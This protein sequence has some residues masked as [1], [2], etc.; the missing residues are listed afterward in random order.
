ME[1]GDLVAYEYVSDGGEWSW[2]LGSVLS[3]RHCLVEILRWHNGADGALR[4]KEYD[5]F[6]RATVEMEESR[7]EELRLTDE[8]T[9]LRKTMI[10]RRA[11]AEEN[12]LVAK[13]RL[14]SAKKAVSSIDNTCLREMRTYRTPP[15][16]VKETL[17][18]VLHLLRQS[19]QP[20]TWENVQRL[21]RK[22]DFISNVLNFDPENEDTALN[23]SVVVNYLDNPAMTVDQVYQASRAAGPLLEWLFAKI[24]ATAAHVELKNYD[25]ELKQSARQMKDLSERL[26]L[27]QQRAATAKMTADD[28][29]ARAAARG[30]VLKKES[31]DQSQGLSEWIKSTSTADRDI[32]TTILS[33]SILC[34]FGHEN[35]SRKVLSPDELDAIKDSQLTARR[36]A[37]SRVTVALEALASR[38]RDVQELHESIFELEGHNAALAKDL[39]AL[40]GVERHLDDS[41]KRIATL[42]AANADLVLSNSALQTELSTLKVAHND[43]ERS[44]GEYRNHTRAVELH[45]AE[46]KHALVTQEQTQRDQIEKLTKELEQAHND[47]AKHDAHLEMLYLESQQEST[48]REAE[49]QK[50]VARAAE[51]AAMSKQDCLEATAKYDA[52][53]TLHETTRAQLERAT[54]ATM[55]RRDEV[56]GLEE[57]LVKIQQRYDESEQTLIQRQQD[58][59]A[60]QASTAKERT[61]WAE[62]KDNFKHQIDTQN[63][64]LAELLDNKSEQQASEVTVLMQT[65]QKFESTTRELEAANVT[66]TQRSRELELEV[67]AGK[68]AHA[69]NVIAISEEKKLLA[70]SVQALERKL[71][72][73]ES[74]HSEAIQALSASLHDA[75]RH[76]VEAQSYARDLAQAKAEINSYCA[77]VEEMQKQIEA[78]TKSREARDTEIRNLRDRLEQSLRE[79]REH[80]T[81]AAT[82]LKSQGAELATHKQTINALTAQHTIEMERRGAELAA[83]RE[84]LKNQQ[85]V[86]ES[87]LKSITTLA[88]NHESALKTAEADKAAL[89]ARLCE[90]A[91][92]IK[93]QQELISKQASDLAEQE[94]RIESSKMQF[95]AIAK[96]NTELA[97]SQER[98]IAELTYRLDQ[99]TTLLQKEQGVSD[100][101][102]REL[103]NSSKAQGNEVGKLTAE[104]NQSAAQARQL[105]QEL[106]EMKATAQILATTIER[107]TVEKSVMAREIE[108]L[109]ERNKHEIAVLH[110]QMEDLTTNVSSF[111][112]SSEARD[113]SK[114]RENLVDCEEMHEMQKRHERELEYI[115]K[116][117]IGVVEQYT[118]LEKEHRSHIDGLKRETEQLRGLLHTSEGRTAALQRE[119]SERHKEI[120]VFNVQVTSLNDQ[121]SKL[122]S[123]LHTGALERAELESLVEERDGEVN[124][125][126]SRVA[127]LDEKANHMEREITAHREAQRTSTA[128]EELKDSEARLRIEDLERRNSELEA[129]LEL[130][131]A[132]HAELEAHIRSTEDQFNERVTTLLNE[133]HDLEA[134]LAESN[135]LRAQNNDEL[136]EQMTCLQRDKREAMQGLMKQLEESW[137]AQEETSKQ[138]HRLQVQLDETSLRAR[139]LEKDLES[140]QEAQERDAA[141]RQAKL[142]EVVSTHQRQV[143]SLRNERDDAFSRLH[144]L[145]LE[146]SD[147]RFRLTELQIRLSKFESP[148][149][150]NHRSDEALHIEELHSRLT[151]LAQD[152]ECN[153]QLIRDKDNQI[154][155]L[156]KK[157]LEYEFANVE[158]DHKRNEATTELRAREAL[159]EESE[160]ALQR[161]R[162][163]RMEH[164]RKLHRI[165]SQGSPAPPPMGQY[166]SAASF[167]TIAST[168]VASTK[169]TEGAA[170]V[171]RPPTPLTTIEASGGAASRGMPPRTTPRT[172]TYFDPATNDR[173]GSVA[174]PLI[175]TSPI[176][177]DRSTVVVRRESVSTKATANDAAGLSTPTLSPAPAKPLASVPLAP[178]NSKG[179]KGPTVAQ[180]QR[181]T[182]TSL[183]PQTSPSKRAT[184]DVRSITATEGRDVEECAHLLVFLGSL[185]DLNVSG[186]PL[187]ASQVFLKLKTIKEKYRTEVYEVRPTVTIEEEFSFQLAEPGKD[188][189]HLAVFARDPG[190]VFGSEV[191]IG[192]V[193]L[194]MATLFRGVPRTRQ[195]A[196]VQDART[197]KAR[198]AGY[199][200]VT[201]RSDDFGKSGLP[202][203]REVMEEQRNYLKLQHQ[204]ETVFPER[205]HAIDVYLSE[206]AMAAES[207]ARER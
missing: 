119:C 110:K 21:V 195:V 78:E 86:F 160:L 14:E 196:I 105:S 156:N 187:K 148:D 190:S 170:A 157:L 123:E 202:T 80:S 53:R 52:L 70:A 112:E 142:E 63:I 159:L 205:L 20:E 204:F 135:R 94:R 206:G 59:E 22:Q 83:C 116:V 122:I 183:T 93:R 124:E 118:Q 166:N 149:E 121:V 25:E 61:Q 34:N 11:M 81:Q 175:P 17:A 178:T 104:A 66:L 16:L 179:S 99:A 109:E 74:K 102:R 6:Q 71:D 54:Q 2:A 146:H 132:A 96:D 42:E 56:V 126:R 114:P 18:A 44:F 194:S 168:S 41:L 33:S 51:E 97:S 35:G 47:I 171:Q 37:N 131:S 12:A 138:L 49:L 143:T 203:Q 169:P 64:R 197:K 92:S 191:R 75:K 15:F 27:M 147:A 95:E 111:R 48:R 9:K 88:A 50:L 19:P 32:S 26:V 180:P 101:L 40:K 163:L 7:R 200:T 181:T 136:V 198:I 141:T 4:G 46:E 150:P 57:R 176:Q 28:L 134:R 91:E 90:H 103:V 154:H 144:S 125:L 189:V 107:L 120:Q 192:D 13:Q 177:A 38:D 10:E 82:E 186:K 106:T 173:R 73:Q 72:E 199:L 113:S 31:L 100:D 65:A 67:E 153:H 152:L 79:S 60:H 184:K 161:E 1:E 155:D 3:Y 87:Q 129:E 98:C 108:G 115:Q 201:I 36:D 62:E 162:N 29:T 174:S 130:K 5:S 193:D 58:L 39:D 140:S 207:H 185:S 137:V 45:W 8:V 158:R 55:E 145:E 172:P 188:I 30:A 76:E 24:G 139:I 182:P 167:T 23:R 85:T 127:A 165:V 77:R 117:H 69:A 89:N 128:L 84:E 133:N 164:E 43:T 68:A 151:V